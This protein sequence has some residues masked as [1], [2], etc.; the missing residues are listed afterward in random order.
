[1]M[2][3]SPQLGN[4]SSHGMSLDLTRTSIKKDQR[5]KHGTWPVGHDIEVWC[6]HWR[7]RKSIKLIPYTQNLTGFRENDTIRKLLMKAVCV[8]MDLTHLTVAWSGYFR[9]CAQNRTSTIPTPPLILTLTLTL[10]LT[11]LVMG[12]HRGLDE[13]AV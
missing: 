3:V 4:R 13:R 7:E 8:A 6:A 5:T 1:M 11:R 2:M 12:R 10:P 9:R